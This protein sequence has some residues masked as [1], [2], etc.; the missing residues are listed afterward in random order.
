MPM[1][2]GSLG[3]FCAGLVI[4][5]ALVN[6]VWMWVAGLLEASGRAM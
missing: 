3:A 4:A 2:D 6:C 5:L 1:P